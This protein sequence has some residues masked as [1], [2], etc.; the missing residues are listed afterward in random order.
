MLVSVLRDGGRGAYRA[1]AIGAGV[2]D[3]NVDGVVGVDCLR[4]QDLL[5]RWGRGGG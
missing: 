1:E 4:S 5:W 2:V 3:E